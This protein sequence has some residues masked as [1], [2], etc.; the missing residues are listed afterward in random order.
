MASPEFIDPTD[1]K[2]DDALAKA[3]DKV[4]I[5][6]VPANQA[7][8]EAQKEAQAALDRTLADQDSRETAGK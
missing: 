1:G 2:I 3:A 4:E 7:L 5:E 8:N 6:G